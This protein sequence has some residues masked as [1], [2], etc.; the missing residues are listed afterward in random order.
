MSWYRTGKITAA[1][2]KNVITGTGT[3]WANNVMG[4]APGQ[5]LIVPRPDGNTL[6]YEILAVDSDTKIRINGNVVDALTSSNY[7]IQTSVSNSYSALARETSAQ[8][9]LY[10]QLLKDWQNITT[11]TGDVTIIAPDGT[12]V[13]IPA[14]SWITDSKTWFDA[15]RELIENAGEAVA[16]AETAR[17]QAVA[18]N[19][20]AQAAKTTAVSSASTASTAATTATGAATTATSAAST[21]TTSKNQAVTARDEAV[22]AA[23]SVN[24]GPL[25]IG[26]P[27]MADIAN[28]DWQNF[29]F[30]SGANYVTNYNTWVNPPTGVT[31]NAGTRVSI[32]VTYISNLA[33]GP[34][35]GLELTPDTG[36]AANFKVY[37]LLCV[38]AA[39]SRV[40]TFNQDWNSAIPVPISGGGTGGNTPATGRAGL[41]LGDV[42]TKNVGTTAGTVAAGDDSRFGRS[43]LST[44]LYPGGTSAVPPVVWA[45]QRL[46]WANPFVGR[47]IACRV[48]LLYSGSWGEIGFQSD[49]GTG[50]HSFGALLTVINDSLV[51]QTGSTALGIYSA[52]LGNGWN[53]PSVAIPA[54]TGLPFR[55]IVW[56]ID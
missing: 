23:A 55:I 22:A 3:Q 13:V 14:L 26:L 51:L 15:N 36:A 2:G 8:L 11:G 28:F 24:L 16:G 32:R 33:S 18:A 43:Q 25:G 20:A 53:L 52:G 38:G 19:T 17:D 50:S 5:A 41:G 10:Q 39:G 54:A 49:I 4:V 30:T 42:A 6:I 47:N 12:E 56:T 27:N 37:R 35:M 21:A 48:E 40:F 31:Y 1:S 34:R 44:T 9:G 29:P 46:S 45:N 7:G